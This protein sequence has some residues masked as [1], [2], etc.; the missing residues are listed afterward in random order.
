MS[1]T[2]VSSILVCLFFFAGASIY[3]HKNGNT[4]LSPSRRPRLHANEY[5]TGKFTFK[6]IFVCGISLRYVNTPHFSH[7]SNNTE[8][9]ASSSTHGFE[10]I[11]VF[12]HYFLQEH[13]HRSRDVAFFT[14]EGRFSVTEERTVQHMQAMCM[15]THARKHLE[16]SDRLRYV[17]A[18]ISIFW[19]RFA[20]PEV[21]ANAS[22]DWNTFAA[23]TTGSCCSY[24]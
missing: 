18:R 14:F 20:Q 10:F 22:D 9:Q 19:G 4:T 8:F 1:A 2:F 3:P 17:S 7:C 23:V 15:K 5:L 11:E 21:Q 24:G 6:I 13:M 12:T 16:P